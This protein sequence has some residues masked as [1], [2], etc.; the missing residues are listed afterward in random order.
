MLRKFSLF[1]GASALSI[2]ALTIV[3]PK[4]AHAVTAALVQIVNTPANPVNTFDASKAAGQMVQLFCAPGGATSP[5]NTNLTQCYK[6]DVA[7]GIYN[8]NSLFPI[9]AGQNLVV[10]TLDIP[11]AYSSFAL[12]DLTAG[13]NDPIER[14]GYNFTQGVTAQFQYPVAGIVFSAGSLVMT[15]ANCFIYGYLTAN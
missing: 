1:I 15:S 9:P 4:A 7:T 14:E 2:I 13:S 10:T 12:F 6:L 11:S 8:F 5:T 3:G